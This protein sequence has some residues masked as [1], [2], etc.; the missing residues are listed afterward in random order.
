MEELHRLRKDAPFGWLAA[1]LEALKRLAAGGPSVSRV[2][3]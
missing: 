1:L 3:S 2:A